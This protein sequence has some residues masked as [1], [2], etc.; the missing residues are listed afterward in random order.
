M[1]VYNGDSNNLTGQG[2]PNPNKLTLPMLDQV[3]DPAVQASLLRIQ[4][5]INNLVAPSGSGGY[6]SLTGAGE[7]TTPGELQQAGRFFVTELSTTAFTPVIEL[8]TAAGDIVLLVDDTTTTP[9]TF[10][11]IQVQDGL[12][13]V[14]ATQAVVL[15]PHNAGGTAT[16]SLFGDL[17]G[18]YSTSPIAKPTVT[19][20]KAGN[21]ALASLCTSLA[22][23][24]LI[25]NS[26]T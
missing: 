23:L 26:T 12:V 18:F 14:T 7:T 16:L 24:G 3:Q 17:I 5:F 15:R 10:G 19:G 25:T 6:A 20:A 2:S 11:Q 8:K 9:A 21:A 1:V 22:N 4:Q 13:D